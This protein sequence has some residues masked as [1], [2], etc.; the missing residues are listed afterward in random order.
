MISQ[1]NLLKFL[2][3]VFFIAANFKILI[4]H[5]NMIEN[6][7][8]FIGIIISLTIILIKNNKIMHYTHIAFIGLLFLMTLIGTSKYNLILYNFFVI[9]GVLITRT[10]YK[11]CILKSLHSSLPKSYD[12]I[13]VYINNLIKINLLCLLLSSII[14]LKIFYL[15]LL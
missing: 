14:T 10:K 2:F 6:I 8:N 4:L 11:K 3:L 12:N 15:Y 7:L 13:Y 9:L 5:E 1:K